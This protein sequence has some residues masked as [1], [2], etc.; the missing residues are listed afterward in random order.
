MPEDPSFA[1]GPSW[2]RACSG[3]RSTRTTPSNGLFY[4][5]YADYA[6]NGNLCL[7]R[8]HVS[9]DDPNVADPDSA[10]LI[11]DIADDPYINHNGGT[12]RFGPDGYP[13]LD[14]RRRRSRRATRMTTPR[15]SATTFGKIH[16]IDVDATRLS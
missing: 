3:S 14:D 1:R 4:V 7:V 6:T 8:Y 12:V 11:V 2:S 5:Y 16:R 9:A 10:Q 13:L 15:T